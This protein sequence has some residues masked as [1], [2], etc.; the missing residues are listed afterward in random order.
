M[1]KRSAFRSLISVLLTL[2]VLAFMIPVGLFSAS[3]EPGDITIGIPDDTPG[4]CTWTLDGTELTI[5]G[6]GVMAYDDSQ[7]WGTEIT[8]V[9][10]EDGVL[11]IADWAF[12]DCA[13]LTEVTIPDSVTSIGEYAFAGCENLT[14]VGMKD[15]YA[16]TYAEENDFAFQETVPGETLVNVHGDW[17]YVV[18]G[19]FREETTLVNYYGTWYYVESGILNWDYTGLVNYYGTWYYVENGVLNWNATT[20]TNFYG[21]WYY[22]ENGVLNWGYTGLTNYYGT[23][24]YVENGVLNW[25]ANLWFAYYGT[26][27]HV[28]NGV[29]VF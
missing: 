8:R 22:V 14:I 1:T 28:V 12:Q 13:D 9:T 16:Q 29:V 2:T 18:D 26:P 23:W 19:I 10:I 20:L 3:A 5:S 21:T 7:P 24:Y 6:K 11:N 15:S 27:Y 4:D 17:Y 25:N